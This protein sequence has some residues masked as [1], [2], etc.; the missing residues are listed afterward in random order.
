MSY[1]GDEV[2]D[3]D[4]VRRYLA[5]NCAEANGTRLSPAR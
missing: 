3:L 2:A 5:E 1:R 4:R